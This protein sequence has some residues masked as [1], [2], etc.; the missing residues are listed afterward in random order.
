MPL[1]FRTRQWC[2]SRIYRD[3]SSTN[4]TTKKPFNQNPFK[5]SSG[6]IPQQ[7]KQYVGNCNFIATSLGKI[8][9]QTLGPWHPER[10]QAPGCCFPTMIGHSS[11]STTLG[12]V[13]LLGAW[14]LKLRDLESPSKNHKNLLRFK[15]FIIFLGCQV[16]ST[17]SQQFQVCDWVLALVEATGGAHPDESQVSSLIVKVSKSG[18]SEL[19]MPLPTGFHI[20][21][22]IAQDTF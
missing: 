15:S 8:D 19:R 11:T 3:C 16:T 10:I 14:C 21:S 5:I 17:F 9:L 6:D 4:S 1:A 12:C 7:N 13:E 20:S 22:E 2:L 18:S